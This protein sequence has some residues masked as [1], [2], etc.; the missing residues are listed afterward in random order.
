MTVSDVPNT[1]L[2]KGDGD[3]VAKGDMVSAQIWVGNG[4][5]QKTAYSTYDQGGAAEPSRSTTTSARSSSTP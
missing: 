3:T 5:T 4:C 1:T 2:T